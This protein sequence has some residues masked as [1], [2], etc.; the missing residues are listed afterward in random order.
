MSAN[1]QV[2]LK[3]A[4]SKKVREMPARVEGAATPAKKAVAAKSGKRIAP[5]R[6]PLRRPAKVALSGDFSSEALSGLQGLQRHD[7]VI[8][9]VPVSVARNAMRGFDVITSAEIL[10]VLGVSEKTLQRRAD[11]TL[12]ANASDRAL[13]LLSVTEQATKVLGARDAAERWLAAPAIGLDR[14][15]P[16]ELLASSEGTEMVKTLLTRM[17]Y[18]VYS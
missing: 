8:Q 5:R 15:R 6:T 11:T 10:A 13:R 12:D 4:P 16:I 9:G 1:S 17:E 2:P 7:M 14:R 3:K 18:G